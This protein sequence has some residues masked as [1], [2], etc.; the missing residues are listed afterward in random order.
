MIHLIF[1]N[2]DIN[3]DLISKNECNLLNDI[4]R[5]IDN[6]HYIETNNCVH[7]IKMLILLFYHMLFMFLLSQKKTY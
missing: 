2:F 3:I 5:D 6:I 7:K 1:M 4:H